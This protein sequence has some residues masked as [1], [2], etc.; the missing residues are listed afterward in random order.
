[1]IRGWSLLPWA[2]CAVMFGFFACVSA[3]AEVRYGKMKLGENLVRNPSFEEDADGDGFPDG[4][5]LPRELCHWD[6]VEKRNGKR[7]LRFTNTDPK[8]YRLITQVVPCRPKRTYYFAV[9]VKGRDIDGKDQWDQ[10]AGI[11]IEWHDAQ[12]NWLGGKYPECPEGTF[13]W[14]KVE[15]IATIPENAAQVSIA[16]YLRRTNTGT[17]WFEDVEV[18]EILPAPLQ[19]FLPTYRG[20]WRIGVPLSADVEVFQGDEG[21]GIAYRLLSQLEDA[22]GRTVWS[23]DFAF[24]PQVSAQRISLPATLLKKAATY[25]WCF[26]LLS[27]KGEEV[28]KVSYPLRLTEQMPKVHVDEKLRLI[29]DGKPFFPLGLYLGPTGDEHL[30]RIAEAGFNTILS[31]GYGVGEDP[32]GYMNRAAKHGLRVI[33]SI[34]DFYEGTQYFPKH[35]G[36]SGLE[37]AREYV[38]KLR[39]HPALLAW[40]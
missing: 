19:V 14:Q 4:W 3:N 15:G 31:Y 28:D 33:Y 36:K 13:D 6:D 5:N 16:L 38:V 17:A 8:V 37:L 25:R 21:K 30:A 18:R 26:S 7:S 20:L 39:N 34:K 40:Y 9:W 27:P 11:C 24:T 32:E 10:G 29:V 2:F 23:G 22:Q 1:M 12:G 35:L